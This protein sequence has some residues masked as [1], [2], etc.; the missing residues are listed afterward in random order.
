M[1]KICLV[2]LVD[3]NCN[4]LIALERALSEIGFEVETHKI[5]FLWNFNKDYVDRLNALLKERSQE[6]FLIFSPESTELFLKE[7]DLT[8]VYS[9]YRSWFDQE[10]I[11][12][13]PHIATPVKPPK[14]IDHLTW[15]S[16]P[17]LRIGFMGRSFANSR[18]TNFVEKLP[19][20]L[21]L[22]L[23]RGSFL[24]NAVVVGLMND[25]GIS[26][27]SI[28]AFSRTETIKILRANK[29][30]YKNVEL[31][32]VEKG[33][34]SG[35]EQ[36]K[37]EYISHLERN[38]YIICTRG[39]E[40]FSFRA[41]EALSR[42]KVPVIIDTDVVLPKEI[43]WDAVSVRVPY[44]SLDRIYEIILHDYESR[45]TREFVARQTKAFSSMA[46]LRNTRWIK[47]L[48]NEVRGRVCRQNQNH[49]SAILQEWL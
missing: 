28:N 22:W 23:L 45:S 5:P 6:Q 49:C 10:K 25:Y 35:S 40:N 47:G 42:G 39:T 31:D 33:A 14:S 46:E 4:F 1:K 17:P 18:L 19:V 34:F 32:I 12:V 20:Q 21:K 30:K 26:V 15:T 9:A 11:R 16:K 37:R 44:E 48:A 27:K 38:T 7:A 43:A 13:I 24:R 3:H 29:D 36:D 2:A 8:I 41:Y